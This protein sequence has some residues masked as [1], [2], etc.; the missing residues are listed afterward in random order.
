M[1]PSPAH[2]STPAELRALLERHHAGARELV[3]RCYKAHAREMGSVHSQALDEALCFGWMDG[4]RRRIDDDSF[5]VRFTQSQP[6]WYRRT[7]VF[8]VMSARREETRQRQLA[9][10]IASSERG[11]RV[12]PLARTPARG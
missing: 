7:S 8:R 6:P 2:F 11:E 4:V 10:L 12:P 3:V 5:S 9:Q 1:T